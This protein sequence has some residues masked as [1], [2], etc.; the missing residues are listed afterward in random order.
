MLTDAWG[1]QRITTNSNNIRS[2]TYSRS[3]SFTKSFAILSEI[4]MDFH[5]CVHAYTYVCVCVCVHTQCCC[6]CFILRQILIFEIHPLNVHISKF[7]WIRIERCCAN[8]YVYTQTYTH[9]SNVYC[10][11]LYAVVYIY[12]AKF[13]YI[14]KCVYVQQKLYTKVQIFECKQDTERLYV[15]VYFIIAEISFEY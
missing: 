3:S 2:S 11:L 7:T 15:C 9:A 1:I 10:A 14:Y 13:T 8:A 6:L 4:Q 5:L 12:R